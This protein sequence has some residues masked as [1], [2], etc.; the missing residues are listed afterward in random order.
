MV[1]MF[2]KKVNT[3]DRTFKEILNTAVNI[4]AEEASTDRNSMDLGG[5]SEE[6]RESIL[7]FSLK[8][9]D[10]DDY[11][12]LTF[13]ESSNIVEEYGDATNDDIESKLIWISRQ[14]EALAS[15]H[16]FLSLFS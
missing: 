7:E 5:Q 6:E 4:A 14:I 15:E 9:E 1:H 12:T 16:A 8:E 3:S 11:S 2:L 13:E 10:I